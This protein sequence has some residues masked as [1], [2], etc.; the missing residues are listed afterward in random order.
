MSRI[1]EYWCNGCDR[2]MPDGVEDWDSRCPNPY[3]SSC[4]GYELN[5]EEKEIDRL[6]TR[7]EYL[8]SRLKVWENIVN[9]TRGGQD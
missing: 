8:E 7:I 6:K 3:D 4:L 5:Q 1:C 9:M 2:S